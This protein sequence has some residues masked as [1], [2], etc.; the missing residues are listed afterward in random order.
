MPG[1]NA[2]INCFLVYFS[3]VDCANEI[4]KFVALGGEMQRF[5]SSIGHS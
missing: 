1:L 4:D 3:S 2:G 5:K